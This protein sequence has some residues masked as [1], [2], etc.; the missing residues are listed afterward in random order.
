MNL[1]DAHCHLEP[2]DF[3]DIEAVI[4]RARAAGL[5]HAVVVGQFQAPGDFGKALEVAA[6]HP[7]FFTPT[8]GIHPHEAQRATE[9]DFAWLEATCAAP[10]VKAVGEAGLDYYYN[11][12]PA[13]VQRTVFARQAAL[14]ARLG[15]ALVVHVREAHEECA[16]ILRA[17]KLQLGVIHCFTGDLTAA[18]RYLDLGFHISLSGIVTYKKTEALQ[19]AVQFTPLDRLMVET[20]SPFLA[21]MPFRG[22]KKRARLG[23]RDRETS[24]RAQRRLPRGCGARN[25]CQRHARLRPGS[26]SVTDGSRDP[27]PEPTDLPSRPSTCAI[28]LSHAGPIPFGGKVS[29]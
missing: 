23:R 11:R 7:D 10:Q 13:E 27:V 22:K 3:P 18:R 24:R 9:A 5:V 1:I 16:D 28:N 21:P 15:K 14:A 17:E 2:H 19:E 12:S 25:H 8:M 6:A 20:D 29:V 26:Y 4:A